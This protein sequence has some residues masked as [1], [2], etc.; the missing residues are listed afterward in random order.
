M[1]KRIISTSKIKI[2]LIVFAIIILV[3]NILS[4]QRYFETNSL[5]NGTHTEATVVDV[6]SE[7]HSVVVRRTETGSNDTRTFTVYRLVYEFTDNDNNVHTGMTIQTYTQE[8]A[9]EITT[10]E[11][12]YD[13]KTYKSMEASYD[14]NSSLPYTII[15]SIIAYAVLGFIFFLVLRFEK[16]ENKNKVEQFLNNPFGK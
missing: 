14:P 1:R 5:K 13:P 16:K 15:I 11:I 4:L 10:L 7:T 8:E 2:F 3:V 9:N 6:K 12:V